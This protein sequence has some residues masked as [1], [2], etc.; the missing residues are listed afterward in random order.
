MSAIPCGR[1]RRH[2][3]FGRFTALLVIAIFGLAVR[4]PP[5]HANDEPGIPK[6]RSVEIFHRKH[7]DAT[8]FY[9]QLTH[10][11]EATITI[12]VT[13]KNMVAS[14]QLPLTVD[15][16]G[17]QEFDLVTLR[18]ADHAKSWSYDIREKWLIG[19]RGDV[20][21]NAFVYAL[22]YLGEQ[23]VV[24]QGPFGT[25]SHFKGSNNEYAIDWDM[26]VGT[27]VAA[28]REG[29]VVC[30]RQDS[31]VHGSTEKYKEAAND[32]VIRHDD[33]TFA[34]YCHLK[35][36]GALVQLGDRV[37]IHQPLALSGNTGFTSGPHLHFAVFCNVDGDKR[38][39]L[40]VLFRARDGRA[41]T[42]KE[43]SR[44]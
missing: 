42:P 3:T 8:T 6:D 18:P 35:K 22:P 12:R 43:G 1:E 40:P 37:K 13:L 7:Q 2:A 25:F 39:S 26:P 36:N 9:A 10:C 24:A 33:G 23:H 29:A 38:R 32:I 41:V 16:K 15:A 34:E 30:V 27:I 14:R 5:V 44:Y 11:N 17:R 21:S 31:D 19:R 4:P 20:T 28:A